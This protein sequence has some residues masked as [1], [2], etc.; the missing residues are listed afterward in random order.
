MSTPKPKRPLIRLTVESKEELTP[1]MLR[2]R[3]HAPAFQDNGM[4]DAYLKFIL[5]PDG[6]LLEDLPERPTTRTYTVRAH[7]PA[8]GTVT[9]DFLT[10]GEAGLAAPWARRCAPGDEILA[11]GPGGKWSP[12][13]DADF[14]LFVG[15]EA[16]LPAIEAGLERLPDD[17]R[18][19]V[20]VEADRHTRTLTAPEGVEARWIV[21]D[22][23]PYREERL[24]EEVAALPWDELGDVSVFAHGERGAVKQL[25][26]VMKDREVPAER[27]SI[28]GYWALGR[29]ED[30]FQAEKRLPIGKI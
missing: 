4:S 13:L 1:S 30:Q 5:G 20:L 16:A 27:L 28:S 22:G 15:D 29:I 2:I 12:R 24:A 14:H 21:R 23:A 6:P 9:V 11:R 25:R 10:H 8:A 18:G 26:R 7:D 3:F 17:A 19:L